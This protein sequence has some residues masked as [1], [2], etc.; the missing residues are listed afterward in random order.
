MSNNKLHT[1]FGIHAVQS[2]L[3]K[4]GDRVKQ[5]YMIQGKPNQR[6]SDL[7]KDAKRAGCA[8][9]SLDKSSFEKAFC[10]SRPVA[11]RCSC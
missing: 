4:S 11:P 5:M 3:Q 7:L 8:V 2:A 9:I 10:S 6:I 1:I